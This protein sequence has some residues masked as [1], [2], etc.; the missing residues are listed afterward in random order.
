MERE[1]INIAIENLDHLAKIKAEWFEGGKLGGFL[2]LEINNKEYLFNVE[3]KKELRQYQLTQINEL[4]KRLKN[5][6]IIAEQIYP[7]IKEQ[8]RELEIPYLEANGNFFF[9]TKGCF[10]LVDTNKAVTL[11][12]EK[13]NR[14][15]TKT[16]LKILFHLLNNPELVNKKQREIADVAGVGLGNIPQVLNGLRE[17][18]YLLLL[19]KG[20]YVWEKKDELI[21]RWID[22]YATELRP[23]LK[24]GT[25]TIKEDWQKIELN[26]TTTTWGGE[27][28]ADLLTNHLRPGKLLLYTKESNLDLIKK[29]KFMP[30]DKGELE[31]LDMFWHNKNDET[32]TPPLL[33]YAELMITGGKRNIET[34]KLIYNDYIKPQ[35]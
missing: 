20:I 5:L 28:A 4:R 29:Y 18:G 17:T 34:A 33:I 8:L 1:I 9:Q 19:K 10:F 13:A 21:N 14:A 12:K 6:I 32:K 3:V 22:G 7:R 24:V 11:R 16:G 23:R 26:K 2:N 25:Y 31:A 27:P 35:L 15:F 30:K